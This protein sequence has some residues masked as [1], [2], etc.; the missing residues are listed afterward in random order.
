MFNVGIRSYGN[1]NSRQLKIQT[2]SKQ[3]G[4]RNEV[5]IKAKDFFL[6]KTILSG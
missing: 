1:Q 3:I 6:P 5:N 4:I 2:L